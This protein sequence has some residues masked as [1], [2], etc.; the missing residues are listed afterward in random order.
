MI[1]GRGCAASNQ[2]RVSLLVLAALLAL[3]FLAGSYWLSKA[4]LPSL[5]AFASTRTGRATMPAL[6]AF[7]LAL[8]GLKGIVCRARL[9]KIAQRDR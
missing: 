1:D 9:R 2:L 4:S 3:L 7:V 5:F 8:V 6:P